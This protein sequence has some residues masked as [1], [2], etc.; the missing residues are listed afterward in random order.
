MYQTDAEG[1]H[2]EPRMSP[3]ETPFDVAI[4][5]GERIE[6]TRTFELSGVVRPVGVVIRHNA[7]FPIGWFIIGYPT[8]F[9]KPEM[10]RLPG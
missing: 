5:P 6:T 3:G 2:Y 7:G 10:V 9:G 4:G 8:W 1:R